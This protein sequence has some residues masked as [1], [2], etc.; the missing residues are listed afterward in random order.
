MRNA[1]GRIYSAL[2]ERMKVIFCLSLEQ[3]IQGVRVQH[4]GNLLQTQGR[5]TLALTPLIP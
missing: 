4:W 5:V 3:M 2:E 1:E